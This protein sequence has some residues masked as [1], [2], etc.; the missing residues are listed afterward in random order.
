MPTTWPIDLVRWVRRNAVTLDSESILNIVEYLY[1]DHQDDIPAD[2]I[3][4]L[5]SYLDLAGALV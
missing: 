4:H 5:E 3:E 2:W 1:Y